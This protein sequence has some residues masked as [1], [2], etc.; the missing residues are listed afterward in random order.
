[1]LRKTLIALVAL[2]AI[3]LLPASASARGG[4]GGGGFHGGGFAGGG[5]HGGGC[6]GGGWRGG[7]WGWRGPAFGTLGVG[8]G[9]VRCCQCRVGPRLG[10]SGLG[11]CWLGR[12]MHALASGLDRLG[13]APCTRERLLVRDV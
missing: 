4:F 11:L 7:G 12:W 5:W 10:R 9:L 3:A 2:A 13:L 1:M 8:V 6:R